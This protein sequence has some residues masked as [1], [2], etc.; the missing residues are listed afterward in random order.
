MN[1]LASP[2]FRNQ[3][4]S[5]NTSPKSAKPNN[6][7]KK[8]AIEPL[9]FKDDLPSPLARK[10]PKASEERPKSSSKFANAHKIFFVEGE[11]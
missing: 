4:L 11:F 7:S 3:R 8:D 6:L 2:N 1:T 5:I 9:S 10:S